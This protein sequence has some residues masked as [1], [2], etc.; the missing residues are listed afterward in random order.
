MSTATF[1]VTKDGTAVYTGGNG[2][3]NGGDQHHP[4]GKWDPG[5]GLTWAT[6]ALLYAPV[7]F[8]GMVSITSAYL[9]IYAHIPA[10]GWHANGSGTNSFVVR[11]KTADWAENSF[12][13]SGGGENL[14]GG[15]G[16][17][18]TFVGAYYDANTQTTVSLNSDAADATLFTIDI[19]DIVQQ[20]FTGSPNYG[21]QIQAS[22]EVSS[23]DAI[24]F[25][26]RESTHKPYIEINYTT[27]TAPNAP[28]GLSPTG[29]ALVNSGTSFTAGGTRSDPDSG[30]YIT[31]YQILVYKDDGTTLV[32]DSGGVATT[33]TPTTFSRTMSVGAYGANKYYQ[34]KARTRDKASVWGP[35]SALQRVKLN[36]VPNTPSS[37]STETD[38]LTPNFSGSFSDPDSGDS[39]SAVQIEVVRVSDGVTMW[40]SG[41]LAAS[42]TNWSKTYAG[43]TLAWSVSYKFRARVKDSN[44]AYSSWSSY[45]TWTT[46]QP[47]GPTQSPRTTTAGVAYGGKINDT[48]PDLTISYSEAFTDHEIY[49]YSN[50]AG[51]NQVFSSLPAAYGSTTSKVVTVTT[52]LTNGAI[53]YWKARV[54]IASSSTWSQWSGFASGQSG[55]LASKFYINALPTSPTSVVAR[56]DSSTPAMQRASDGVYIVTTTTPY[57]EATF[58]DPDVGAYGDTPS[59]R[60]VEIY[61]D[62]TG[63]L[64]HSSENLNPTYTIPM[65]YTVPAATLSYETTYKMRWRF[66]DN[67]DT[68]GSWSSYVKFKPTQVSTVGSVTPSGVVSSPSFDIGWTFSSPGGKAQEQYRVEI[69]DAN[70]AT[71]YDS[72]VVHSS[73]STHTLPGGYLIN[74]SDYTISVT[75][76]DT[77]GI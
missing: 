4:V 48:T 60:I 33:G 23:A 37:L 67:S 31:A 7:S 1:T 71:V 40:S 18:D 21:V 32:A 30:D 56:N 25:Y 34:W 16:T 55:N 24:E 29:S 70:G 68:Y 66:Q 9:K 64:V 27:N 53:Y 69:T 46:A 44:A 62:S 22:G 2:E 11:R 43:S 77:D 19:T 13:T 36:T 28:T 42:G 8:T 61:N 65:A 59:A 76:L 58:N 72:G 39:M 50:Q 52:T 74:A 47:T 14:W 54:F 20:W 51:T 41:D 26:S 17:A 35:Y 49:V 6:R 73:A 10:S 57:L 5:T 75:T 38:T 12:G 3:W 45:V 15:N 63:V